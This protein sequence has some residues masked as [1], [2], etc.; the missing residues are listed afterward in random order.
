MPFLH[1]I[2]KSASNN[3]MNNINTQIPPQ[4][5]L[6][7]LNKPNP[8]PTTAIEWAKKFTCC[9]ASLKHTKIYNCQRVERCSGINMQVTF[10]S[11]TIT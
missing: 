11:F 3:D 4:T 9:L 2:N 7:I 1:G 5:L 8:S 6:P 10:A